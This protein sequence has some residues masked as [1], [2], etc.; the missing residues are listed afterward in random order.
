[1]DAETALRRFADVPFNV[2][3]FLEYFR[4]TLIAT[5]KSPAD[6]EKKLRRKV[7]YLPEKEIH[8]PRT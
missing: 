7:E 3:K 6:L 2:Q 5:Y 8:A 4:R 1:M